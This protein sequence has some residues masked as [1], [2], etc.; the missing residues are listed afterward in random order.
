MLPEEVLNQEELKWLKD[1]FT[2]YGSEATVT[3][4]DEFAYKVFR[5]DFGLDEPTL[6]NV[7]NVRANKLQ[8]LCYL[9]EQ[10]SQFPNKFIPITYLKHNNR[11]VGYKGLWLSETP[12]EFATLTVNQKLRFLKAIRNKLLE[13]HKMGIIYGDLK[14]DNIF[15]NFFNGDVSFVDIDNMQINKWPMDSLSR[16]AAFFTE[17]HGCVDTVLDSYMFNLLTI[18]FLY[19]FSGSYDMARTKLNDQ[20]LFAF[21]GRRINL[22]RCRNLAKKMQWPDPKT[23]EE[24]FIDYF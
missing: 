15:L 7:E 10:G 17:T 20:D 16:T 19:N 3:K 4:I 12:M 14:D 23:E 6:D 11:F 5:P 21:L 18:N 24:Y 2:T 1:N 8:K 22:K 9:Y 13:F